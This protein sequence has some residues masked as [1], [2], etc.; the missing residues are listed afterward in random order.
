MPRRKSVSPGHWRSGKRRSVPTA[1]SVL[2]TLNNLALLDSSLGDYDSAEDYF[3]RAL[4]IRR[5]RLGPEN[6]ATATTL[7]QL[8]LLYVREGDDARAEP[9]LVQAVA[10]QEKI[11][12]GDGPDLARSLMQLAM[13]YDRRKLYDKAE[14]S[15]MSGPWKFA[16]G[17]SATPI[18]KSRPAWRRSPGTIMRR[19]SWRRRCRSTNRR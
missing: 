9:L 6:Q 4:R 14:P 10:M 13:L 1:L 18:P 17:F 11:A 15:C 16:G 5:S 2:R 8:G 3:Q 19:A 12:H 7:S